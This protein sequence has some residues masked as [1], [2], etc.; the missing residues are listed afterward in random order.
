MSNRAP[1]RDR[2]HRSDTVPHPFRTEHGETGRR[3]EEI[4][5]LLFGPDG[6]TP[7][8][9]RWVRRTRI[10]RDPKVGL[11]RSAVGAVFAF[12]VQI[13]LAMA[14]VGLSLGLLT[15]QPGW[16]VAIVAAA[17]VGAV[18]GLPLL[19][20]HAPVE[21][22]QA[23]GGLVLLLAFVVSLFFLGTAWFGLAGGVG[24]ALTAVFLV[25][26]LL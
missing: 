14:A 3:V 26:W 9:E 1:S 24:A 10:E 12:A 7:R 16:I 11:V 15:A 20:D 5:E 2:P 23:I 19:V 22:K 4:H 18:F 6:R 21:A 8:A 17:S 25:L 13:V